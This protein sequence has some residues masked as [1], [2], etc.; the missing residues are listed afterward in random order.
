MKLKLKRMREL[1]G[2]AFELLKSEG[3][4]AMARRALGFFRRRLFGKRARY[5]PKK[6]VLQAQRADLAARWENGAALPLVSI[7][8][9]LYNTPEPFLRAPFWPACST[10]PA[11][12]G[13]CAWRTPPMRLTPMW[14]RS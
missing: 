9:P 2:Y 8:V 4:F 7:C 13:S 3:F 12:G 5:L 1:L 6:K 10:R 11:P 14:A